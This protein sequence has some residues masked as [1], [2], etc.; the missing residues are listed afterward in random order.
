[1]KPLK[2][3]D[4]KTASPAFVLVAHVWQHSQQATGHSWRR[5]NHAM[6]S[7]MSLAIAAGLK[8]EPGDMKSIYDTMRGG[9]WFPGERMYA[10]AVKYDNTSA[11]VSY[12]KMVDRPPF[13]FGGGRLAEGS[14][15]QWDGVG[16]VRVTSFAKD[17]QSLIAC[18]YRGVDRTPARKVTITLAQMRA[19]ET[20]RTTANKE[21][22]AVATLRQALVMRGHSVDPAVVA[23]WN[24]EQRAQAKAW[25]ET[26]DSS[27]PPAF[28]LTAV[29]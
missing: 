24:K 29:A 27:R 11:C 14:D 13:V 9:Y 17:G 28:V 21:L 20:T 7:A 2:N 26:Y 1:M 8:F 23:G 10:E 19:A 15:L 16:P 5:L 25:A 18:S 4:K 22:R 6:A 3:R 12:E